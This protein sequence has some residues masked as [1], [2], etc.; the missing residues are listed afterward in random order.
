MIVKNKTVLG[1][2]VGSKRIGLALK[3]QSTDVVFPWGVVTSDENGLKKINEI[4]Q[5]EEVGVVV[6]GMPLSMNGKKGA[7]AKYV[8]N[9]CE[10]FKKNIII[11]LIFVDER[12][13]SKLAE[14][15]SGN[16]AAY[17]SIDEI[18]AMEILKSYAGL[19]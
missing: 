6:V 1:I 3:K 19:S 4:I 11:P 17:A 12:L 10:L 2:D 8:E 16:A 5:N 7:Q 9:W 14:Q 18:S 15:L 13:S